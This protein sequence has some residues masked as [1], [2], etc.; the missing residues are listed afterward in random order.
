[1]AGSTGP[2][3]CSDIAVAALTGPGQ[4]SIVTGFVGVGWPPSPKPGLPLPPSSP[5]EGAPSPPE[6]APPSPEPLPPPLKLLL[7][8]DVPQL[9]TTSAATSAPVAQVEGF[10]GSPG[11]DDSPVGAVVTS[12]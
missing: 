6:E 9:A 11:A 1:M 5:K 4:S 7:F 8:E 10:M 3:A 2:P 12:P